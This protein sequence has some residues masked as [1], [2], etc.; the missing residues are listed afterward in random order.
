[1]SVV[2]M[3]SILWWG[4]L[5]FLSVV[6]GV[7]SVFAEIRERYGAIGLVIVF[8]LIGLLIFGFRVRSSGNEERTANPSFAGTQRFRA[9]SVRFQS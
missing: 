9:K 1:M 7:I 2:V 6:V 5:G 8:S 3:L 4:L